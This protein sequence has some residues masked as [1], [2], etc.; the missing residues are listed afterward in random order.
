[1]EACLPAADVKAR[2]DVTC[3]PRGRPVTPLDA[4]GFHLVIHAL[5]ET[6]HRAGHPPIIE[7]RPR[8]GRSTRLRPAGVPPAAGDRGSRRGCAGPGARRVRS[9]TWP[10]WPH[11]TGRPRSAWSRLPASPIRSACATWR[12]MLRASRSAALPPADRLMVLRL[13][14]EFTADELRPLSGAD[15]I[16]IGVE[17]AWSS[18]K[19]LAPLAITAVDETGD[20]ATARVERAGEPVPIRL[21]F[22]RDAGRWRLD[23]VELARGSDAALA[24]TLG[25]PRPARQGSGRGGPALGDRGHLGASGGQGPVGAAA[26]GVGLGSAAAR[27]LSPVPCR[28]RPT[29][30]RHRSV[31]RRSR[32]RDRRG[33]H[34]RAGGP[35][36]RHRGAAT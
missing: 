33:G 3:L 16:R 23:L 34:A 26:A 15:L 12:S 36:P 18:P 27:E 6:G 4:C 32:R 9:A 28:A 2:P 14:H 24:E 11:G 1:M 20:L 19:V 8:A 7:R 13:R 17:E 5:A 31:G 29:R 35:M 21:L 25:L 10:R 30:S 22:R